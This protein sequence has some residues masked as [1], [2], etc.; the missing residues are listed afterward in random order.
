M[1]NP[2]ALQLIKVSPNIAENA[3]DYEYAK[4][5]L[6][7]NFK[8]ERLAR[9]MQDYNGY[10]LIDDRV[11]RLFGWTAISTII[12]VITVSTTVVMFNCLTPAMLIF[13][14]SVSIAAGMHF[15]KWDKKR[16]RNKQ[17]KYEEFKQTE[18]EKLDS[19]FNYFQEVINNPTILKAFE[20]F[21]EIEKNNKEIHSLNSLLE[22]I[23][24]F[25]PLTKEEMNE[26]Q[27]LVERRKKVGLKMIDVGKELSAPK[28]PK[29]LLAVPETPRIAAPEILNRPQ[30]EKE[31]AIQLK[32]I[33]AAETQRQTSEKRYKEL[34]SQL[35]VIK[36][37]RLIA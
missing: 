13:G 5:S 9:R 16:I 27:G 2:K 33:E 12:G 22:T 20:T 34:E 32:Q 6:D 17:A 8:E 37:N 30:I 21:K 10:K 7:N 29:V 18:S 24:N 31:M 4:Y 36:G 3:R 14:V 35:N 25:R 23:D 1:E 11:H 15:N 19:E 28:L 26:Y